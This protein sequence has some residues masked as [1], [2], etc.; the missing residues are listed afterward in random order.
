MNVLECGGAD[1]L[2]QSQRNMDSLKNLVLFVN[3]HSREEL[4]KIMDKMAPVTVLEATYANL[5]LKNNAKK[6]FTVAD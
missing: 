2:E 5:K 1:T 3:D 6:R 4:P